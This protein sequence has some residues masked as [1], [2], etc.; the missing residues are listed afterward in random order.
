[1]CLIAALVGCG[2]TTEDEVDAGCA[3]QGV[4]GC[5]ATYDASSDSGDLEP[6]DSDAADA[7]AGDAG[8]ASGYCPGHAPDPS[9]AELIRCSTDDDCRKGSFFLTLVC[10]VAPPVY[11]CGGP[12]P[13]ELC[14]SDADCGPDGACEPG[15]CGGTICR[16]R[17]PAAACG[18]DQDC[19]DGRCVDKPCDR[20]GAACP[21]DSR[22]LPGPGSDERGCLPDSC[23]EGYVCPESLDC[24]PG[25]GSDGH[26]CL[27][28]SCE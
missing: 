4:L 21:P 12:A 16:Q 1:M 6:V 10:S 13:P 17:C 15:E 26:G 14:I 19:I 8:V 24:S 22:C 3:A 27:R 18:G 2:E 9:Q 5:L 7:P 20:A 25:A 11:G 23:A 28:R